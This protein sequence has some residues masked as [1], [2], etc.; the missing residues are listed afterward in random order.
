MRRQRQVVVIIG[1]A[2]LQGAGAARRHGLEEDGHEGSF[3]FRACS[4]P[5][6]KKHGFPVLALQFSLPARRPV[7]VAGIQSSWAM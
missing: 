7:S 5:H 4:I 1:A 2:A 3:V 6:T